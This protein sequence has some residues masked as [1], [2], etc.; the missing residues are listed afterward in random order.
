MNHYLI[1]EKDPQFI[2]ERIQENLMLVI[3]IQH[4]PDIEY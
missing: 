2:L 3:L 4:Y 1:L